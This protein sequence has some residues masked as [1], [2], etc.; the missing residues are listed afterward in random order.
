M[1]ELKYLNGNNIHIDGLFDDYVTFVQENQ[2]KN[3]ENWKRFVNVFQSKEDADGRWRGEFFGKQ[4]RGAS[5]IYRY[6]Q[7]GE[8][9]DI[10][11]N[12]VRDILKT[13]ED[14][15]RISS[16]PTEL[17]FSDWDL[18]SRKYVLTG[19]FHFYD[20]CK[21]ECLKEQII[22]VCKRHADYILERIGKG[23]I[24]ITNTSTW[25]GC[26]N[27]CTILEPILNL[28]LLT[29]EKRY[30]DFAEY[31]ISTGGSSDC[32]FVE[33]ALDNER[34]PYQYPVTKA[35]EMMSFFEGLLVYYEITE[36]QTYFT[37]ITNFVNKIKENEITIIGCAG[38]THE[39]FD[40]AKLKQTEYSETIMQETCVTVT[41]MRILS[42]LYLLTR[43]SAYLDDVEVSGLNALYGS[44]NVRCLSQLNLFTKKRV[45]GMTFDSYSPLYLNSRGRGVG[46]YMDFKDGGHGGCCE[47]IGACGIALMPLNSVVVDQNEIM[48]NYLFNGS[49]DLKELNGL[50]IDIKSK[51]PQEN[52]AKMVFRLDR[53]IAVKLKIRKP[54]W[55][56]KMLINGNVVE[57][58]GYYQIEKEIVDHETLDVEFT[59]TL[60][61][62]TING[63]VAFT[64]GAIVLALDEHKTDIDIS[65]PILVQSRLN[66]KKIKPRKGELIRIQ[67]QREENQP[68]LLTDYQSCGKYWTSKRNKLSVWLNVLSPQN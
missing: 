46:G 15:G 25:W 37:A 68:L 47:A 39:L 11:E 23:K 18:W 31:I 9:Y 30:F 5:M 38:C 3:I 2:L 49:V 40:N 29:R 24:E 32:N 8:L 42:R 66:Y 52:T 57:T 60:Q 1:R 6:T 21:D 50:H 54:E 44:L 7:D 28:Y 16:Y 56:E 36:N 62:H 22:S 63:K 48:I 53:P 17:E 51:Y 55:A 19:L 27:S 59:T 65:Q 13:Q 34:S 58:V 43:N 14:S 64:Y 33:L 26:V 61:R 67:L 41:W 10:L 12:T 35:Y 4:M 20:I 45:K